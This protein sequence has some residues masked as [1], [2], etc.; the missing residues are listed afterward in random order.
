VVDL[1]SCHFELNNLYG[2]DVE[3]ATVRVVGGWAFTAGTTHTAWLRLGHGNRTFVSH[4]R[5]QWDDAK[6]VELVGGALILDSDTIFGAGSFFG[7]ETSTMATASSFGGGIYNGGMAFTNAAALTS[8]TATSGASTTLTDTGKAWTTNEFA[9]KRARITGGLG[10]GQTRRIASNTATALTVSPAWATTPNS[11][12]T[13]QVVTPGEERGGKV[14]A[15][16]RDMTTAELSAA[17]THT[18][19]TVRGYDR[20]TR[21]LEFDV[22]VTAVDADI[23]LRI[24]LNPGGTHNVDLEP[25]TIAVGGGRFRVAYTPNGSISFSGLYNGEYLET[26]VADTFDEDDLRTIDITLEATSGTKP[27]GRVRHLFEYVH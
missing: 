25:T 18:L 8:G 17:S 2:L 23:V 7:Q 20:S 6:L 27:T 14:F 10:K 24:A 26:T 1:S 4:I 15:A 16:R 22:E 21:V 3:G 9:N 5:L 19:T 11:T 12:S 13:Y